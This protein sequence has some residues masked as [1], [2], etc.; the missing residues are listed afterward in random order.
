ML[1]RV[2]R[3]VYALGQELV[4]GVRIPGGYRTFG[5]AEGGVGYVADG[6]PSDAVTVLSDLARRVTSG[7]ISV[8]SNDQSLADFIAG[9][10]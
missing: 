4:A 5:L 3:A 9:L 2:D 6:L 8:P 1:K 7:E 10:R